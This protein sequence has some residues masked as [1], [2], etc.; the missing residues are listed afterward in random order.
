MTPSNHSPCGICLDR[1]GA[2]LALV[3]GLALGLFSTFA[4]YFFGG[5]YQQTIA[6]GLLIV[7]LLLKP[8]GIFGQR[9]V[10]AV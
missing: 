9:Q 1:D 6:V 3:G 2:I 5:E 7:V 4:T 10:R 8:E